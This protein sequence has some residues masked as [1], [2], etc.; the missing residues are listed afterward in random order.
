MRRH[1]CALRGST[2]QGDRGF[3]LQG[4][5]SD[6]GK[7][8]GAGRVVGVEARDEI[9]QGGEGEVVGVERGCGAAVGGVVAAR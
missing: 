5:G 9:A 3:G 1:W 4:A 8:G 6:S 7:R 2:Q